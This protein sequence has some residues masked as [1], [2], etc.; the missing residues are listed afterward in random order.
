MLFSENGRY[1]VLHELLNYVTDSFHL[2]RNF[3]PSNR[4]KFHNIGSFDLY[5]VFAKTQFSTQNTKT[6]ITNE[7]NLMKALIDYHS[8]AIDLKVF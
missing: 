4:N 5:L 2:S 6:L 7:S 1:N 8:E 3:K